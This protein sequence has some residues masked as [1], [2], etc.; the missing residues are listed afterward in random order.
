MKDLI[1]YISSEAKIENKVLLEKDIILHRLLCGLLKEEYFENNFVFK[2]GTCLTKCYY[3][4][5][6]FSEDL[7]FSWINQ[8]EFDGK[9]QKK[10]RRFLSSEIDKLGELLEKIAKKQSLSFKADKSNKKYIEL[11]GSNKFVTFKFWYKSTVLGDKIFIKIQIN[12][13]EL[14]KYDF[15]TRVAKTVIKNLNQKDFEFLFPEHKY[16]LTHPKV[17]CYDIKEIMLEKVRAI[18]TRKGVKARDFVDVFMIVKKEKIRLKAL[19]KDILEKIQ[20]M[21]RFDKYIQNLKN[22]R[23]EKFVL[24]EE[25]KLMLVPIDKGF[26]RF[27]KEFHDFLNMLYEEL[28]E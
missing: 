26:K 18:L 12:F 28:T 19:K 24:G 17:K 27:L 22:F 6:R 14:F 3:G 11:G 13:V 23:V 16:L 20:F 10:I 7:D 2:G 21:L 25:E 9:S 5:Y 8:K 1:N 15:T 4:Y